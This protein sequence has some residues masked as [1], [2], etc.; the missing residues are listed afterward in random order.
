[1]SIASS[2]KRYNR[3]EKAMMRRALNIHFKPL[4]HSV[5]GRSVL[6][7][8]SVCGRNGLFTHSP[9][10]FVVLVNLMKCMWTEGSILKCT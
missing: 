7:A 10:Y 6:F 5:C 4:H 9:G 2:N 8:H 3:T 1:M